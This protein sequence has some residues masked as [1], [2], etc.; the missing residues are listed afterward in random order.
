MPDDTDLTAQDAPQADEAPSQEPSSATP[1][2]SAPS[3]ADEPTASESLIQLAL[4]ELQER[5]DALLSEVDVLTER[6]LQLEKE[7]GRSCRCDRKATARP[8]SVGNHCRERRNGWS[9]HGRT[10]A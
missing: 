10:T 2:Q 3:G 6:K 8:K 9:A 7:M 1:T 4:S 5:R